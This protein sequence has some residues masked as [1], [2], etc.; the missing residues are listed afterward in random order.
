MQC[1]ILLI[2]AMAAVFGATPSWATTTNPSSFT[3]NMSGPADDPSAWQDREPSVLTSGNYVHLFWYA[4]K[5]DGTQDQIRYQRSTDGGVTFGPTKVMAS[6]T[7]QTQSLSH[8]TGS[9]PAVVDGANVYLFFG[10]PTV[11]EGTS[12]NAIYCIRS[13][14]NGATFSDP[15]KVVGDFWRS[16]HAAAA[17][18][19]VTLL[20]SYGT[21]GAQKVGVSYSKDGGKTFSTSSLSSMTAPWPTAVRDQFTAEDLVRDGDNVYAMWSYSDGADYIAVDKMYISA[22]FDGGATFKT[23]QQFNVA[24][25]NDGNPFYGTLVNSSNYTPNLAAVGTTCFVL[26]LNYDNYS[27]SGTKAHSLRTRVLTNGTTLSDPITLKSYPNGF[28]TSSVVPGDL[29]TIVAKG[30]HVYVITRDDDGT[31]FWYSS[32]MGVSFST[33]KLLSTGGWWA[34]MQLDPKDAT[35]LKLHLLTDW[36]SYLVSND[37]GNTFTGPV[38]LGI[39]SFQTL[40]R[41]KLTVGSDSVVHWAGFGTFRNTDDEDIFYRR[42]ATPVAASGS[43]TLHLVDEDGSR[44][45]NMQVA[46]S[47]SLNMASAATVE[48]WVKPISGTKTSVNPI[49]FKKKRTSGNGSIEIGTTTGNQLYARILTASASNHDWLGAGVPL[50]SNSWSHVAMTYDSGASQDNWRLYLNGSLKGKG[51]ITTGKLL[52]DSQPFVVGD[53]SA[54]SCADG[55]ACG[56]AFDFADLRLWSIA[57]SDEQIAVGMVSSIESSAVGLAAYYTFAN[58]TYDSSTHG[59][60]GVLMYKETFGPAMPVPSL[61]DG[62]V[63]S[64]GGSALAADAGGVPG[65][66]GG[67][68]FDVADGAS[69]SKLDGGA[70]MDGSGSSKTDGGKKT[71]AAVASKYD[72]S[73]PLDATSPIAGGGQNSIDAGSPSKK[74]GGGCNTGGD[75]R[76]ANPMAFTVALA[77]LFMCRRRRGR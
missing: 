25:T 24:S 40:N 53:D 50:P 21:S 20:W 33:A 75:S 27:M 14:D 23:A 39:S 42:Y 3:T 41:P 30:N 67:S 10:Q 31:P 54:F 35:G 58:S 18:G 51:T 19:G 9:N 16:F 56:F 63:A 55:A 1:R 68:S 69:P 62:G 46:A 47:P 36:G 2:L 65:R 17:N 60:H 64:D 76:Y 34:T 77:A 49:F 32:D 44:R 12:H 6:S 61:P 5:S 43:G 74:S 66:D 15:I 8:E 7:G 72:A 4:Y 73:V 52:T 70:S 57:R 26:W 48:F 29:G 59:N 45:D 22:S 28:S 13:S 38:N 11:T 71:D 37:G